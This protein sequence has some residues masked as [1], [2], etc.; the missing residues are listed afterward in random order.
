MNMK[1]SGSNVSGIASRIVAEHDTR[2]IL[3]SH[4]VGYSVGMLM[5]NEMA[6]KCLTRVISCV[7]RDMYIDVDECIS[8]AESVLRYKES[9]HDN[10]LVAGFGYMPNGDSRE[11]PPFSQDALDVI[12]KDTKTYTHLV[13]MVGKIVKYHVSDTLNKENM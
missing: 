12:L 13:N 7:N 4:A 8:I 6:S 3:V 5:P 10:R 11:K 2:S 1:L 9:V